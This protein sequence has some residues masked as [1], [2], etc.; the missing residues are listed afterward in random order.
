MRYVNL[1]NADATGANFACAS[2]GKANMCNANASLAI[3][4]EAR[5]YNTNIA[6]ADLRGAE[7]ACVAIK[8]LKN[9]AKAK[10]DNLMG[11]NLAYAD[12]SGV[13]FEDVDIGGAD[14]VEADFRNA[15]NIRNAKVNGKS[16]R[17][18]PSY[19]TGRNVPW[20]WRDHFKE[21]KL[22]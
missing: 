7:L 2:L 21:C 12:L 14:M 15:R 17:A 4:R 9:L 3:F 5:M 8:D 18:T 6:G 19:W 22:E 1:S 13:D 10:I 20:N 16:V 11:A